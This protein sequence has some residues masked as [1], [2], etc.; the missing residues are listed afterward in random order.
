MSRTTMIHCSRCR[1]TILGGHSVLEA[2]AG[3]L[4]NRL[5]EPSIDLCC[6]CTE[7]FQEF[8]RGPRENTEMRLSG[9]RAA[10]CPNLGQPCMYPATSATER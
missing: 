2:K 6:D 8:M 3:H 10:S 9:E 7:R 1:A 4:V 5:E